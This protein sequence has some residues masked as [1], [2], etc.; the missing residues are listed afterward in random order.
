MLEPQAALFQLLCANLTLN[1][2]NQVNARNAAV[3]SK[4]GSIV[5]PTV[6]YSTS[7]NF[8]SLSLSATDNSDAGHTVPLITLDEYIHIA[9]CALIKI[10]VEG[11]ECDVLRG[12]RNFIDKFKPYIFVENDRPDKS[13]SLI[14]LILSLGYNPYWCVTSLYNP[15]NFA[16]DQENIFPGI[17]VQNMF[18]IH[19]FRNI[20][21]SNLQAAQ[22]KASRQ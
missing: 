16:A 10:D 11:M 21:A 7:G 9:Q 15:D 14:E 13:D 1:N 3:G 6:N 18:C 5:V 19:R 22:P 20:D 8:G 12:G 2:L 4:E 17:V